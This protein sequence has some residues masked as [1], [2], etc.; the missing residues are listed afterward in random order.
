MAEK[1]NKT[2][3]KKRPPMTG[4][5]YS[6]EMSTTIHQP[7]FKEHPLTDTYKEMKP[8]K[9]KKYKKREKV[10]KKVDPIQFSGGF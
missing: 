3:K 8:I 1:K 7:K 5:V 10:H 4:G 6:Y 9:H 2:K